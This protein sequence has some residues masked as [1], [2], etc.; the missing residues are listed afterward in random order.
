M[1][2]EIYPSIVKVIQNMKIKVIFDTNKR[3]GKNTQSSAHPSRP[4][5]GFGRHY[6][7]EALG[8]EAS[9]ALG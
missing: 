7:S 2:S 6:G 1:T 4:S 8:S 3:K 5:Q 9:L